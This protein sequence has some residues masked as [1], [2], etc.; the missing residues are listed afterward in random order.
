MSEYTKTDT[1]PLKQKSSRTF[2]LKL[3]STSWI[4]F[5][6]I[7]GTS[8]F[9]LSAMLVFALRHYKPDRYV[10]PDVVGKN[11]IEVH[12][13]L[14]R[15]QLKVK[16][17]PRYFPDINPGI[18]L[19]QTISPG[20]VV[21]SKSRLSLVVNKP[22]PEIIVPVLTGNTLQTAKTTLSRMTANERVYSID[23]GSI[24]YTDSKLPADIIISQYPP[25]KEKMSVNEK[26]YLLVSTGRIRSSGDL[27]NIPPASKTSFIGQNIDV[28][29]AY[30]NLKQYDYR[31]VETKE[32]DPDQRTGIV[33]SVK[34][35]RDGKYLLGV[36]YRKS[37]IRF[38]SGYEMLDISL[39]GKACSVTAE[40][41]Y[42][43]DSEFFDSISPEISNLDTAS[44]VQ[45]ISQK[46]LFKSRKITPGEKINL[47]FFRNKPTRLKLNCDNKIIYSEDIIMD[48]IS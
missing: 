3:K 12:N 9:F 20:S 48:K 43:K 47:L 36:Y 18:I 19:S 25:G 35:S 34:Q 24:T 40:P 11:Y 14:T 44:N 10:M 31:I 16:I 46:I 4:L 6:L 8:L 39:K 17:D 29:I 45:N 15:I 21:R 28:L 41:I 33:Y 32:P 42:E 27:M 7:V 26:I 23:I 38:V 1:E 5:Y 22:K 13:E 30:F 37:K 2:Y